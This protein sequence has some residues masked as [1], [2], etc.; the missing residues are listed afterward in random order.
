[1]GGGEGVAIFITGNM[2]LSESFKHG[3]TYYCIGIDMS[4][5]RRY[6]FRRLMKFESRLNKRSNPQAE[7]IAIKALTTCAAIVP[8]ELANGVITWDKRMKSDPSK[9]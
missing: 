3:V 4:V 7:Y 5:R 2:T 8:V 6:A 1:M 9:H